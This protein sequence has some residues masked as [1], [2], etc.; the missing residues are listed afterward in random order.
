MY[1][2][3]KNIESQSNLIQ[4][5]LW[6]IISLID[7]YGDA[8]ILILLTYNYIISVIKIDYKFVIYPSIT[9]RADGWINYVV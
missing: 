6:I 7:T 4:F 9:N 3:L 5:I 8:I 2:R 1:P